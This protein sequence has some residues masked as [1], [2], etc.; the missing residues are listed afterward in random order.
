MRIVSIALVF[1]PLL[2]AAQAETIP[3]DQTGMPSLNAFDFVK[4]NAAGCN[5]VGITFFS[6]E[7]YE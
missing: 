5:T 1:L 3:S 4:L 2:L 6:G 7:A